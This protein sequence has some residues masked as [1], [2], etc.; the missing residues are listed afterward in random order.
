MSYIEDKNIDVAGICET[1]LTESHNA[2]TAI[3]KSY[4]FS[5][6]HNH[7]GTQ[8]GG[9]T[10]IIFKPIFRLSEI[11]LPCFKS[12][13]VTAALLMNTTAKLMLLIVYRTGPLSTVFNQELDQLLSDCSRSSE[14]V[15]L[16]FLLETSTS[17]FLH[18]LGY[19]NIL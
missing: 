2:T 14:G 13:E 10:A 3:I 4:G 18:P 16:Y 6:F 15:I 19:L 7:R 9:G 11:S 1:W 5:L 8:K 17:I 12:F